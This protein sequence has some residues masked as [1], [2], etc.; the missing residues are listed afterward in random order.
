[1]NEAGAWGQLS[2][3]GFYMRGV[4]DILAGQIKGD[5]LTV[6]GV[7]ADVKLSPGAAL[8]SPVLFK[9]PFARAAQLQASAVDDEMKLASVRSLAVLSRQSARPPAQCR[10][11]EL[12]SR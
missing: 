6:V 9:Q 8:Y 11:D 2:Q 4:I 5:H 1:M 7:N 10:R 3:Q 12:C